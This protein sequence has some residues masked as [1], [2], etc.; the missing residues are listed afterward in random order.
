M[1][2][3]YHDPGKG[4]AYV[5]CGFVSLNIQ[6]YSFKIHTAE[7][8]LLPQ[9]ND[10]AVIQFEATLCY[11]AGSKRRVGEGPVVQEAA[12][13]AVEVDGVKWIVYPPQYLI[14]D[15]RLWG[16]QTSRTGR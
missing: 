11:F 13:P 4:S 2:G 16:T 7:G 10:E 9:V 14:K 5:D 15:A 6:D 3:T 8:Y 12:P 1:S